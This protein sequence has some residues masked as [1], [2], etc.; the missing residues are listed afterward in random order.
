VKKI[1]LAA[2]LL[3]LAAALVFAQGLNFAGDL[4]TGF[5]FSAPGP[6]LGDEL[7]NGKGEKEATD[8]RMKG[9]SID[10][11]TN[12]LQLFGELDG[13][14][15]GL[16]FKL[17]YDFDSLYSELKDF[18]NRKTFN[19][20]MDPARQAV[21]V[22]GDLFYNALRLSAGKLGD[23]VWNSTLAEK[24]GLEE[25]STGVRAE[26]K[27]GYGISAGFVFR[28]PPQY[29]AAEE[30]YT[31]KRLLNE[32]IIGMRYDN[33]VLSAALAIALDGND[34]NRSDEQE[35]TAGFLYRGIPGLQ[36]GFE[37][38]LQNLGW[39][40]DSPFNY[41]NFS[42]SIMQMAGYDFSSSVY[43]RLKIYEKKETGKDDW[44]LEVYPF[45]IY[46]FSRWLEAGGEL[47]FGADMNNFAE[48][49]YFAVKPL[50]Y[51]HLGAHATLGVYWYNK[52]IHCYNYEHS[53]D[54]FDPYYTELG[55]VFYW[56]F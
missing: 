14:N 55:L 27:P 22:W 43:G 19:W 37:G 46:K 28:I 16:R 15:Y 5:V 30:Q 25:Y 24:W 7:G 47:G 17:N 35:M 10:A 40:S 51:Y 38:K 39:S 2:G 20:G 13:G 9:E 52:F 23:N 8:I 11:P 54:K 48:T 26:I 34:N 44:T 33:S 6:E 21:W 29:V 18:D 50:L 41:T 45:V 56:S 36:V 42:F 12:R 3:A 53:A 1:V 31:F 49:W 4:V 32:M